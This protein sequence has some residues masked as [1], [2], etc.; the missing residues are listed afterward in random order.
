MSDGAR[1]ALGV[2]AYIL[3]NIVL[4]ALLATGRI[5]LIPYTVLM[6][7]SAAAPLVPFVKT[8]GAKAEVKDGRLKV[9]ALM[10]SLDIPLSSVTA[11]ECRDSFKPGLK[12]WG[13]CGTK[14]GSGDFKNAE[15]PCYT[16]AGDSRIGKFILVRYGKD[17]VAVFNSVDAEYTESLYE[18]IRAGTNVSAKVSRGTDAASYRK[19]RKTVAA[20][21]GAIVIVIIASVAVLMCSGHVDARLEDDSL[22]IDATMMHR[23]VAYV[24]IESAELRESFDTGTRI[25]GFA[26]SKV[27]AG[28]FRNAEFGTYSLAVHNGPGPVIVVHCNGGGVL[29]FDAGGADATR[30]MFEDLQGRIASAGRQAMTFQQSASGMFC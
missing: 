21:V 10:V 1:I 26:S 2:L 5:G 11:V 15:F 29:V 13:Y 6:I 7:A 20:V 17:K 9:K 4:I 24:D 16:Y 23:T 8:E 30:A 14:K 3:A 18:A 28:S 27:S 12:I 22:A 25:G 19:F